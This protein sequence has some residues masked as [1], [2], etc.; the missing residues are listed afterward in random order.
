ML[1]ERTCCPT[2]LVASGG[3]RLAILGGIIT[4]TPIYQDLTPIIRIGMDKALDDAHILNTARILHALGR[5]VAK[6]KQYY[7][8][9][10]S[11][12]RVDQNGY[13][14]SIETYYEM[15]GTEVR[16]EFIKPLESSSA[17][18]TFLAKT[19][20][21]PPKSVVVKFVQRYG[22]DAHTLLA[23]HNFAPQLFYFGPI[24]RGSTSPSYS[25][26]FMVVMEYLEGDT[27]ARIL[28]TS[29]RSRPISTTLG[30]PK[31][32]TEIIMVLHVKD[33]VFGD[34]R[35]PNI[36]VTPKGIKLIDF[37][38]AGTAGVVKYP[39]S[40]SDD[41][42]WPAGAE[43]AEFITK[44]HDLDMIKAIGKQLPKNYGMN[45]P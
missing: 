38:W 29:D 32:L 43:G 25:G 21:A 23:Q 37:D 13:F 7:E 16:F 2:F 44:R 18:V 40:M 34:L 1:R 6:L 35:T 31:K 30:L 3:T 19:I 24:S 41:I 33:F 26:L 36:M 5:N 15:H 14:P 11:T 17:C 39:L 27:L 20:E 28:T 9:L 8:D 10:P 12:I 42:A 4:H 45:L 22:K